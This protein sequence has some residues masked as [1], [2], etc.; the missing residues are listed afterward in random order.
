MVVN[1]LGRSHIRSLPTKGAEEGMMSEDSERTSEDV[2]IGDLQATETCACVTKRF[3]DQFSEKVAHRVWQ[4][5]IGKE[6]VAQRVK[7]VIRM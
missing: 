2:A 7:V 5:K 6:A 1:V 3:G 4:F